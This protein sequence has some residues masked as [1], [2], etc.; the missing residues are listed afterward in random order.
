MRLHYVLLFSVF[1]MTAL[2]G[3]RKDNLFTAATTLEFT[4]GGQRLDTLTFDTVFTT[5]GSAVRSFVVHNRES[6]RINISSL[7]IEGGEASPFRL[8]VDGV[9]GKVFEN[10][11]INAKD[12]IYV[13]VAVTIDPNASTNPF[14]IE[15]KVLFNVNGNQQSVLLN[16]WGQNAY[17][18]F[19]ETLEVSETWPN[20]KPHVVINSIFVDENS[21]LTI[22]QGTRVYMHGNS[23]FYVGGTLIVNG[24]KQDSVVFQGDRLEPYFKDLPGNWGFIQFLRFSKD[25]VLTHTIIKD[26]LYGVLVD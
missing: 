12:S 7:R 14:V 15:D 19:G 18:H 21:T 4:S 22:Q 25:N 16:A 10:I 9:P 24:T 20:D 6:K 17:F 23:A 11:E 13:F 3:C 2:V 1:A 8:N 26:A 5:Q